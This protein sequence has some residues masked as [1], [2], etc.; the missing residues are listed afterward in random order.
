M[1][2]ISYNL[3]GKVDSSLVEVLQGVNQV[4]TALGIRFFV[5]GAMARIIVLEYCHAI[6]PAR[7]ASGS[8]QAKYWISQRSNLKN[9]CLGSLDRNF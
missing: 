1:T 7:P 4:A 8:D 5:V 9:G 2:S 3:S 6:R